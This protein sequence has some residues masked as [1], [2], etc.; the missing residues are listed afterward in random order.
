MGIFVSGISAY[1]IHLYG[2]NAAFNHEPLSIADEF[3]NCRVQP[4]EERAF[5]SQHGT[6]VPCFNRA[7]FQEF[8]NSIFDHAVVACNLNLKMIN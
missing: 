3:S 7:N 1:V 6:S 8:T 5:A 4:S 2:L